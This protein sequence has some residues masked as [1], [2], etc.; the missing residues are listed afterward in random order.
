[1]IRVLFGQQCC[2]ISYCLYLD[3]M[4]FDEINHSSISKDNDNKSNSR[5]F[6]YTQIYVVI[7]QPS[8]VDIG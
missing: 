8:W 4:D 7:V 3:T 1:M 6:H 2:C 5:F